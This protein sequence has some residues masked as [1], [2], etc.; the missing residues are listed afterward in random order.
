MMK[1]ITAFF[2]REFICLTDADFTSAPLDDS[3]EDENKTAEELKTGNE[4]IAAIANLYL[5]R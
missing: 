2:S 5:F 4:I 3:Q 1:Q